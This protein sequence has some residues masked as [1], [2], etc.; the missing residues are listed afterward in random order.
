MTVIL[1]VKELSHNVY[2]VSNLRNNIS[3]A[4]LLTDLGEP[5]KTCINKVLG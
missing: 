3:N 2:E 4:K 5:V 1:F